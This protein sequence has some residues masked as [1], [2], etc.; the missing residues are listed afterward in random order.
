[1]YV[2]DGRMGKSFVMIKLIIN[3]EGVRGKFFIILGLFLISNMFLG[4]LFR[5]FE[6]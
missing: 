2:V 1:M 6:F 3:R 5:V 4:K